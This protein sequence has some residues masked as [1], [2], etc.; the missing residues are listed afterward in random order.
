MTP[1][2]ASRGS[3]RTVAGV[4]GFLALAAGIT[5]VSVMGWPAPPAAASDLERFGSCAELKA[6]TADVARGPTPTTMAETLAADDTAE[7]SGDAGGTNTVVAGVDE[8]DVID[9]VDGGRLLVSRNG[10]L[11]LVDLASRAVV[12]EMTGVPYDARISLAGDTVWVAGSSPDGLGTVVLRVRTRGD[13]LAE[14]GWWSTPGWLLDARRTGDRFHVVVVDQPFDAAAVPFAGG[15]VPCEDM[16]HPTGAATTA[17]ATLVASLPVDGALAPVAV[18]AVTGSAGNL[19]VTGESVYLATETWSVSDGG[20]VDTGLHRFDLATLAPTGSGSVP[21]SVAGRFAMSEHDGRLRVATSLLSP[22]SMPIPVEGDA[23]AAAPTTVSTTPAAG[24]DALAEVF[25]L[26]TD[27]ALDV[28]GRTGR[29]GHDHETIQGVRFVDDI[30]YVVTFRQTDPF[31]VV[32]LSV[33]AQPRVVGELSIPGFSAYLHPVTTGRVVGFGPDGSGSVS[34][35]LFDVT[36]PTRPAL[37]DEVRLGDDSPLLWDAH[38]YVSLEGNRFALPVTD[39]P[40]PNEC[41]TPGCEPVFTG[42]RTGAVVLGVEGDRLVED[43][44]AEL[45]TDGSLNAE[46]VVAAADGTWLLLSWDRLVPTDG[47]ADIVLPV[48]PEFGVVVVDG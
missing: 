25:V 14:D 44:R 15:P 18:A 33:A 2:T 20:R 19:L 47:G 6:W 1:A 48:D 37:L 27:G 35:R 31:W 42:G 45:D 11:A 39:W 43:E 38:A 24:D 40:D 13:T 10:A 34:A 12:A 29:F 5:T 30:A 21:G 16:W 41:P 4:L 22:L 7:A 32:D 3:R 8:I 23:I 26:D 28:V 9:I 46:R 36:D 17:A